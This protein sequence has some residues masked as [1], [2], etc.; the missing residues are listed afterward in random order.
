MK[1]LTIFAGI[2][3][4]GKT[5]LYNFENNYIS[6]LGV[7]VNADELLIKAGGNWRS[8]N[9]MAKSAYETIKLIKKCVDDGV[10]YN[11]ETTLVTPML[12]N[13]ITNAKSLGYTVNLLFIGTDSYELCDERIKHRVE[14]G[15]H[16]IDRKLLE[17]RFEKQF[18][19]LDRAID[20]CDN[21]YLY[22][23]E[24]SIKIVGVYEEG[25]KLYQN[26]NS[27]WLN[28]FL[29]QETALCK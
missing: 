12:I 16:D 23:N 1:T 11:K 13:E 25:K 3:G 7:R 26:K 4:V 29:S 5:T 19:Y 22:E 2:N 8:V 14:K 18:Q 15:G 21:V 20:V 10:S 6:N 28:N 24:E 17:K 27:N 9:D